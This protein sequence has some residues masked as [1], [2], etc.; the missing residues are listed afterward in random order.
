[1]TNADTIA[2][3]F[4]SYL[5]AEIGDNFDEVCR[6]N[7]TAD[8]QGGCCAS[9]DFCDANMV[10]AAAFEKAVG[11]EFDFDNPAD[12]DLWNAAWDRARACKLIEA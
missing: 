8:Y 3:R 10:M 5:Q 2:E 6:R 4:A 11:R 1:M 12:T 9:H 7:A